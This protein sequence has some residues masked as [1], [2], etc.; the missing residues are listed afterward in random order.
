MK[1]F[2]L[3]S[4][5]A[6]A[7]G[8]PWGP[9][10]NLPGLPANSNLS[11]FSGYITVNATSG[12]Q[13]FFWLV[14]SAINPATDPLVF[15]TNGGPGCSSISG[16]MSEHGPIRPVANANGGVSLSLNQWSWH[17]A[18]ASMLYVEQPAG[19][20]FS[21]SNTTSDYTVGDAQ[22]ALDVYNF[23]QG[24]YTFF[25]QYRPNKLVISG[26]SYGGHFCT[27][28]S[29]TIVA[30]NQA[31]AGNPSKQI[32]FAG[33]M[34]GNPWTVA[35]YDN[36]GAATQWFYQGVISNS[37]FTGILATC[38]MSDVG[39]LLAS[40]MKKEALTTLHAESGLKLEPGP[41]GFKSNNPV[42]HPVTG[43]W[44]LPTLNGMNC[45]DYTNQAD[46]EMAGIDIYYLMGDVCSEPPIGEASAASSSSKVNG[47]ITPAAVS[48]P[49]FRAAG[50]K[51]AAERA[52]RNAQKAS[53]SISPYATMAD[54][55]CSTGASGC[56]I[57]YDPCIDSK[58]QT[59]LNYPDVQ[60]ALH[61]MPNTIP[62]GQWIGCS[63]VV[64]Y[65]Y[66]D[67]LSSMIPV[68]QW[69]FQN[70]PQGKYL[71]FS[72]AADLIVPFEGTRDW[73]ASM[74]LPDLVPFQSWI[75]PQGQV[76]GW[77]YTLD[78]GNNARLQFASIRSA[79]HLAPY[80]QGSRSIQLFSQYLAEL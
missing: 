79:G 71:A 15:W 38:N 8:Q 2:L 18:G 66:T 23:M 78:A 61:V 33:F 37:S 62:G 73:I 46:T 20:G 57:V 48:N 56:E 77:N 19:V 40:Q 65:S 50:K 51:A 76:G 24:F 1:T 67:L 49:T 45:N 47:G 70:F 34:V 22:A 68:Y 11:M 39:P 10:V 36:I 52:A 53:V 74:N 27:R 12:R 7:A 72:G 5:A 54:V 43:E 26:E 80:T 28:S 60:A 64:N 3:L 21:Y 41:L 6:L 59:Y 44:A 32:N 14:E 30:M 13:L 35:Y 25:P 17:L 58:T 75:T 69:L 63:N 4:A 29:Q 9:V 16:L 55:P 42:Q 31:N